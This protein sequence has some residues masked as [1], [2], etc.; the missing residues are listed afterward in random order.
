M[1][2]RRKLR[3]YVFEWGFANNGHGWK[4]FSARGDQNALKKAEK[5]FAEQKKLQERLRSA[6]PKRSRPLP[7]VYWIGLYR[8]RNPRFKTGDEWEEWNKIAI[9]EGEI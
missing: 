3:Q 2:K 6:R 9:K 4:Y 8:F 5:L 1:P 7:A